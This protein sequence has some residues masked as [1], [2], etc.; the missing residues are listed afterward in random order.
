MIIK[1]FTN[2]QDIYTINI[3]Q[4]KADNWRL[5][6]NSNENNVWF[7]VSNTS[8]AYVVLD[9][10][11]AIKDIPKVV[12]YRCAVLCKMHSKVIPNK[13]VVVNYTYVKHVTKG[14]REGQAIIGKSMSITI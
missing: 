7:H 14:F 1:C 10:T 4:N 5:L 9:T 6:D 2:G 3:G 11:F 12:I 13:H 8:S